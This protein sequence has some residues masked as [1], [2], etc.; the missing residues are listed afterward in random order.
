M[1][2]ETHCKHLERLIVGDDAAHAIDGRAVFHGLGDA[3]VQAVLDGSVAGV[4]AVLA[5]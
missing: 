5:T 1:D 3:F 2:V 4:D